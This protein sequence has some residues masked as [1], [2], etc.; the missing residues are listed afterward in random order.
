MLFCGVQ[1]RSPW[2]RLST[3]IDKTVAFLS[4]YLVIL[5]T[6]TNLDTIV[7][8]SIAEAATVLGKS[9]RQIRYLIKTGR[10]HAT[11]DG[12]RW[13]IKST[14]LPLSDTERQALAERS[15]MA[16]RA[17]DKGL[18]PVTKASLT[19]ESEGAASTDAKR[20]YSV[21]DLFAFQAGEIIYRD[22][23][24]D[25]GPTEPAAEFLFEALS[26]LSRA[27]HCYHPKDKAE[28]FTEARELAAT[29]VAALLLQPGDKVDNRRRFAQRIE[30]EMIPKVA[31][32]VAAYEKRSRRGRFDRFASTA[33][34]SR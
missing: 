13:R 32:L 14:D 22:V 12:H 16:R 1:G 19:A 2:L 26:L 9:Q 8:L 5:T 15:Q 17:F 33:G 29:A 28:R 27:C 4:N 21:T 23:T 25:L 11:K 7:K 10:L 6:I 34:R 30:Q 3:V 18:E 20:S 31:G 24:R